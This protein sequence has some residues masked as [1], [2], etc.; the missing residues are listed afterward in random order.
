MHV[1]QSIFSACT[2]ALGVAITA[3]AADVKVIANTAVGAASVSADELKAVFLMTKSALSDGSYIE[4]VILKGGVSHDEFLR[5][6][7][8]KTDAALQTYYRSLVF[9]G[10]GLMP[11]AVASD[12]EAVAYVARTKG[13]ISYVSAGA[14]TT[15]VKTLNVK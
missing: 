3:F 4:P 5:A 6:Y 14:A 1:P 8:G 15:G 10:K 7:L 2:L 11:K 13:A 9:A 12:A